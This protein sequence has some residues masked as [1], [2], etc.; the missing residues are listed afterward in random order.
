MLLFPFPLQHCHKF[1]CCF[2]FDCVSGILIS[3][4]LVLFLATAEVALAL[5]A[6]TDHATHAEL[7]RT[8]PKIEGGTWTRR[9]LKAAGD[10]FS[11]GG[12]TAN[13]DKYVVLVT[14]QVP[15]TGQEPCVNGV[16]SD[17][18]QAM[19]DDGTFFF[20]QH[21]YRYV[22]NDNSSSQVFLSKKCT[23]T[24]SGQKKQRKR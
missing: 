2:F 12:Y 23:K 14:G 17:D 18:I 21:L 6:N 5:N 9:A 8:L 4:F 19:L 20:L 15:T 16:P 3:L 11:A 24:P 10:L 1:C 7:I 13:N 22:H